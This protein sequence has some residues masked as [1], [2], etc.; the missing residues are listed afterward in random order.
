VVAFL[1]AVLA[2]GRVSL[3]K[4]VIEKILN[5]SDGHFYDYLTRFD[6][7]SER[8]RFD[9]IYY[10]F[11]TSEDLFALITLMSRVIREYGTIGTLFISLYREKDADIGPTLSRFISTLLHMLPAQIT[12]GLSHL[13]PSPEKGSACKRLNL[14]LRWMI[15]PNDGIDFGLWTEI[16]PAKLIIPLDTHIV[17]IGAYVNLS[18]RK[19]PNWK[20]AKEI[21]EAL[22]HC[23][24][25]DPLKYDFSLCHLGISDACPIE[26]DLD[27]CNICPLQKVCTRPEH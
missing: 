11:N 19:S 20:M 16:P 26:M 21:T 27:K 10:R 12:P 17:R 7:S 9:G 13:F 2:Y 23:E 18:T 14:F 4:T 3:F 8:P 25:I 1:A 6:P 15:R 5:L 24:P 22:K